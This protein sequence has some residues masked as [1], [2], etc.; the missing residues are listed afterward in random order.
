MSTNIFCITNVTG[1][2]A[3]NPVREE[4]DGQWLSKFK[5]TSHDGGKEQSVVIVLKAQ[6]IQALNA[7]VVENIYTEG[8]NK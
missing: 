3:Q 7:M 4:F 6:D 1:I 8:D 5:I 2:K